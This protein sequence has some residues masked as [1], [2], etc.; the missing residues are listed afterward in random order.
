[1]MTKGDSQVYIKL[2]EPSAS[3]LVWEIR[4]FIKQNQ[5]NCD[6]FNMLTKEFRS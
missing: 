1:M 5:Q 2:T 3:R 6:D 4:G